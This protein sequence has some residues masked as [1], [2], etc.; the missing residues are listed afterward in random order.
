VR[1]FQLENEEKKQEKAEFVT[2]RQLAN[3]AGQGG[4]L[5]CV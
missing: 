4:L 3:G 2:R 5:E 1:K